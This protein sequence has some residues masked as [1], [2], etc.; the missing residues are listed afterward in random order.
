MSFTM[1]RSR[2]AAVSWE[3]PAAAPGQDLAASLARD[4]SLTRSM[5]EQQEH[6]S[7]CASALVML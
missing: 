1:L 3:E 4:H 6:I 5:R 2:A 7:V